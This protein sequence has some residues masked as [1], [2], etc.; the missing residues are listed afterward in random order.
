ML[1]GGDFVRFY[2]NCRVFCCCLGGLSLSLDAVTDMAFIQRTDHSTTQSEIH[3]EMHL[4]KI[5]LAF[6][7]MAALTFACAAGTIKWFSD[8]S[9]LGMITPDDGTFDI[10][11]VLP[12]QPV[13]HFC[14]KSEEKASAEKI[15]NRSVPTTRLLIRRVRGLRLLFRMLEGSL[16][17]IFPMSCRS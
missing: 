12:S 3:S 15:A 11:M 17:R 9:G 13:C 10:L 16:L 8:E 6:S 5:A 7:S 2:L 1:L 4:F 14:P